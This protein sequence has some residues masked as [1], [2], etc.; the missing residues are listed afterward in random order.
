MFIF[1]ITSD[2][3]NSWLGSWR[4]FLLGELQNINVF[5]PVFESLVR[6]GKHAGKLSKDLLKTIIEGG[7]ESGKMLFSK[8]QCYIAKIGSE[9]WNSILDLLSNTANVREVS[10]SLNRKPVVLVVDYE[11]QVN[12]LFTF[13]FGRIVHYFFIM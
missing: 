6:K 3:E 8:K 7:I 11:L 9:G 2:T 4:C 1:V 10:S 12:K 5:D 13:F